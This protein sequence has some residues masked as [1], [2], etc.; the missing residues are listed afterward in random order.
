[1]KRVT[2]FAVMSLALTSPAL[3]QTTT[4]MEYYHLDAVGSVRAVSN[5][6]GA[7]IRRHDDDPFGQMLAT[8]PTGEDTPRFTSKERDAE[9]F[10][11]YFGARYYSSVV[12]R[13]TTVD[14]EL[15]VDSV[16]AEPQRWNRYAYSLNNPL[17][18]VDPDGRNPL[19]IMGGAGAAV[20]AG[21][22]V[23]QNVSSGQPWYDNIAVEAGKGFVI[24]ATLGAA[25]GLLSGASE[26]VLAA[27]ARAAV[28]G[29]ELS[30]PRGDKLSQ[31]IARG[32]RQFQQNPSGFLEFARG[33]VATATKQETHVF[34]SWF[35]NGGGATIYRMGNQYLVV[36]KDGK[37]LSYVSEAKSGEGIVTT[38]LKL[39]GK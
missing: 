38:Y 29:V 28:A 37:I 12:G 1:M 8:T 19:L 35:N 20:Y 24:G 7:V 10:L 4:V 33:F 23:Y 39:G 14:P 36:A 6:S 34:A 11:D 21:W 22:K 5:Q 26:G 2:M 17:K 16:L 9:T 13:F 32:G 30:L 15:D 3:A 18:F 27:T 31:M 25:G